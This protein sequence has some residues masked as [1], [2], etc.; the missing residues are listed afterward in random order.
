MGI[1]I[2]LSR[3]ISPESDCVPESEGPWLRRTPFVD[4]VSDRWWQGLF[5]PAIVGGLHNRIPVPPHAPEAARP[6]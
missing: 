2:G 5:S 4:R 3:P 6:A 1:K